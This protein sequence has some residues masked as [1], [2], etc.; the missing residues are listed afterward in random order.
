MKGERSIG[1]FTAPVGFHLS[2]APAFPL[3]NGVL[4]R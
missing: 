1:V 4:K 2:S 3:Q